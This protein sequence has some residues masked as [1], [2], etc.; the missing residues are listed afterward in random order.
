MPMLHETTMDGAIRSVILGLL[1]ERSRQR[2]VNAYEVARSAAPFFPGLSTSGLV[3]IAAEEAIACGIC[4]LW[5]QAGAD[6]S[7]LTPA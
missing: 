3:G 1:A 2:T 7:W 6:G 4:V 5:E